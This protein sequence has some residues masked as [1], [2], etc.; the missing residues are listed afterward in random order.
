MGGRIQTYL[1]NSV[2]A[3]WDPGTYTLTHI[4]LLQNFHI[5]LNNTKIFFL[6]FSMLKLDTD[7]LKEH[8]Q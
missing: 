1:L 3:N 6:F 5:F 8:K 4:H 7:N 2:G